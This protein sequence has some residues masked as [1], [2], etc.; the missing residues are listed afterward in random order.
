ML[1]DADPL[2]GHCLTGADEGVTTGD[3]DIVT[4]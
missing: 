1:G 3:A 2:R 4:S